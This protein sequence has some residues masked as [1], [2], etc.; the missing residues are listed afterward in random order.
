MPE[1]PGIEASIRLEDF[2]YVILSTS[3]WYKRLI[4]KSHIPFY[5]I[6]LKSK[7]FLPPP[8]QPNLNYRPCTKM[9]P[10][11]PNKTTQL[12]KKLILMAQE[13][14]TNLAIKKILSFVSIA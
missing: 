2:P 8:Q 4:H 11:I 10:K 14:L 5:Q 12:R 3:L 1:M 7:A 9:T 13:I 6:T